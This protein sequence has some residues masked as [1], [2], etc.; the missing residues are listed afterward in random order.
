VAAPWFELNMLS[1]TSLPPGSG[2]DIEISFLTDGLPPGQYEGEIIINCNDPDY[3]ITVVPVVLT[4]DPTEPHVF[5]NNSAWDAFDPG[6]SAADDAAIAPDKA[7][8]RSGE[9]AAFANYTSY[10]S[11]I[12][13]IIIDMPL[14]GLDPFLSPE[15]DF[16]FQVGNSDLPSSW[17]PAPL[18]QIAIRRGAGRGGSDRVTLIWPDGAIKKTWLQ[19]TVLPT[20]R[21]GLETADVFYFGN[22]VG[23]CGNTALTPSPDAVVNVSDVVLTRTNQRGP[24]NPTSITFPYDYNRDR[25][26]NSTDTIICRGNQAGP[27]TALKLITPP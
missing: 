15:D 9:K 16:I 14:P 1:G 20:S 3:G 2:K 10:A 5:Y 11:G 24:F 18:P 4:V 26:V 12:N 6:A 19:V 23:E 7:P 21:T 27:F 17:Q 13:G 8:L 22:A 25:L